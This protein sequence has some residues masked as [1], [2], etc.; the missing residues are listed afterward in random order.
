MSAMVLSSSY[1]SISSP[2]GS[3][4]VNPSGPTTDSMPFSRPNSSTLAIRADDT[5]AS[6]MK[7]YQPKRTS[8]WFHWL[9]ARLLTMAAT[10]PAGFPSLYAR[11]SLDSQNSWAAP[12]FWSSVSIWSNT[13]GGT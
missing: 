12:F 2:S 7:S 11:Y 9:F 4:S 6:S 5:S 1:P 3:K 8:L 10:L 13:S